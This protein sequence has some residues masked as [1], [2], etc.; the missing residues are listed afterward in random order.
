M[1]NSFQTLTQ[2][3]ALHLHLRRVLHQTLPQQGRDRLQLLLSLPDV[4]VQ[5]EDLLQVAAGGQVVLAAAT[6]GGEATLKEREN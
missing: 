4:G 6:G 2:A 5:L 1:T 3:C